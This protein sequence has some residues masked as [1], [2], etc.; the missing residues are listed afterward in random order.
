MVKEFTESEAITSAT[1]VTLGDPVVLRGEAQV[2]NFVVKTDGAAL[3]GFQMEMQS[4]SGEA[5]VIYVIDGSWTTGMVMKPFTSADLSLLGD[6]LSGSSIV[7]VYGAYA[8]RFKAKTA[9][10]TTVT[11]KGLSSGPRTHGN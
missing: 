4:Y 10:S 8:V 2:V 6:G 5:W 11:V 9:G 1:L 7:Q 3:T